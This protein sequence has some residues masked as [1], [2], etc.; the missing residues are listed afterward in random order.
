MRFT[1]FVGLAGL[2]CASQ[3]MAADPAIYRAVVTDPEVKLR[4]GPSDAFP[5]TSSLK[6]GSIVVVER[7]E[8]GWLAITAPHGS[9]S[10]IAYSFV[11]DLSPD[12][13]TPKNGLVHAEGEVTIAVGKA[14][15]TQPLDVRREKL[16]QGTIVLLI[17]PPAADASGKKWWPIAPPA[18]D[19]RYLPKSA[20]QIDKPINN[21]VAV[22]VTD[23]G[24]VIP[25]AAT[26][27]S[28]PTGAPLATVPGSGSSPLPSAGV[29]ASKPAVNHPLWLQAETAE[30]EGRLGDAEKAYFE[31]AAVM[32]APGGDHDIANLC[33]TRIHAIREKKRN[34]SGIKTSAPTPNTTPATPNVLQP[35]SKSGR[36]VRP[37]APQAL[38]TGLGTN[39]GTN[40]GTGT[41]ANTTDAQW[42]GPGLLRRTALTPDGT[43]SPAYALETSPG[44][45]KVYVIAGPGVKLEQYLGKTIDV[46]GVPQTRNK[47]SKPYVIA[48]AVEPAQ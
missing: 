32:N 37:G 46:Y 24:G 10:W 16:P 18:G 19:V 17:G 44:V 39:T 11:E 14:G 5:E 3:A 45:V 13:Q 21:S 27:V 43:G 15:D 41:N 7:E 8:N 1:A 48:T 38:P 26:P 31:L 4:A 28:P 40:T 23:M 29:T 36:G 34:A 2:L 35:P 30:R 22:R 6:R 9:V 20:V 42:S 47:L 25:P 12:R 33:Y